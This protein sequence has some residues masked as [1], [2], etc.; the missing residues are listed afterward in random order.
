MS[1]T[2]QDL[3]ERACDAIKELESVLDAV[4][5]L[6]ERPELADKR[7]QLK[8]IGK[9][10]ERLEKT[11][12]SVPDGLRDIRIQLQSELQRFASSDALRSEIL[13]GL[14]RV[15]SRCGKTGCRQRGPQGLRAASGQTHYGSSTRP[16]PGSK[17]IAAH[18]DGEY[19]DVSSWKDIILATAEWAIR[20]GRRLPESGIVGRNRKLIYDD[21][22]PLI[23]GRRSHAGLTNGKYIYLH[24]SCSECLLSAQQ[25]LDAV[26]VNPQLLQVEYE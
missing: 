21:P 11:G 9:A 25:L 2:I 13:D 1:E 8:E 16:G 22:T 20:Q 6:S 10:I 23:E 14:E 4:G 7:E 26:G 18:I 5:S 15:L 17:L 19:L 3:R 12:A 24:Y